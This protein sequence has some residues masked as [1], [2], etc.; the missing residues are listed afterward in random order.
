M[1]YLLI[2]TLCS[3]L[4]R[5]GS[6]GGRGGTLGARWWGAAAGE[7]GAV[8]GK[9]VAEGVG[10]NGACREAGGGRRVQ[11]RNTPATLGE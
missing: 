11:V 1:T 6:E 9:S 3:F 10:E 7:G 8:P 5:S 2:R 4:P